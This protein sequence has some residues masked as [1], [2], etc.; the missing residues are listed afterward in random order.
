MAALTLAI[1]QAEGLQ[2]AYHTNIP[3]STREQGTPNGHCSNNSV[4]D[5]YVALDGVAW[6]YLTCYI[7]RSIPESALSKRRLC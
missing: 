5:P 1:A 2:Q 3:N 4:S 7:L 6:D